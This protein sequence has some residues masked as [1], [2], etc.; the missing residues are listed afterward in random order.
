MAYWTSYI[1][2]GFYGAEHPFFTESGTMLFNPLVVGASLLLPALA[3]AGFVWTR[4]FRY[5]PFFLLALLVGAAIEVAGFP[6][7]T[8][9]RDT[10]EWI[11]RNFEVLRFMRT[12]QKAAPLVAIGAAGLLGLGAQ[13]AWAYLQRLRSKPLR[14]VG[15]VTVPVGLAALIGLAALPLVRGSAVEQQLTWDRIPPAWTEAG[16]DLDRELP[17]QHPRARTAGSDIRATT[18]GAARSTRSFRG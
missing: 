8:P 17:R 6:D 13:L 16:R 15:L 9:S 1:G 2:V 5:A 12:T 4:R 3:V 11:Y 14:R 7:N 10:M 18:S